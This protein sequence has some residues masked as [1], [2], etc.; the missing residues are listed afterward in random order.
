MFALYKRKNY[1]ALPIALQQIEANIML[2]RVTKRIAKE[3]PGLPIYTIHD[4]VVTLMAYRKR[5][6]AIMQEEI[7]RAIG[8]KP[9][10]DDEDVW[11]G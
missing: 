5:V 8:F 10:L 6:V 7:E 4:S 11:E 3:F 9:T 2:K 1:K